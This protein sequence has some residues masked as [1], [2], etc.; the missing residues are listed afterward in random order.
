MEGERWGGK[1]GDGASGSL[2]K[3]IAKRGFGTRCD[4]VADG[5]GLSEK[6]RNSGTSQRVGGQ[7]WLGMEAGT[8]AGAPSGFAIFKECVDSEEE[9]TFGPCT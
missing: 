3:R 6:T 7:A 5:G 2:R 9:G 8:G 4:G 1:P